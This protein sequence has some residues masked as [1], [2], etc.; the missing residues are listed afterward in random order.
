[1]LVAMVFLAVARSTTCVVQDVGALNFECDNVASLSD[2]SSKS[3]NFAEEEIA[4]RVFGRCSNTLDLSTLTH[5]LRGL[6]I[7]GNFITNYKANFK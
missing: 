4:I 7:K 1:M 2:F 6:C 5:K 3:L